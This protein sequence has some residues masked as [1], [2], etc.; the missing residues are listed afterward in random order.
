MT[1][2]KRKDGVVVI[3]PVF[4][5]MR[6]G[7]K[8]AARLWLPEQTHRN[9]RQHPCPVVLE[10]LAYRRR[11]ATSTND[12][13]NHH[14]LAKNGFVCAR[15]DFRGFGDSEGCMQD[16]MTTQEQND[17]TDTIAYLA[18]Q[19]FSNGHVGMMGYSWGG[20]NSALMAAIAPPHLGA[21]I[22][23]DYMLDRYY[24][25][26]HYR[27][28]VPL[29]GSVFWGAIMLSYSSRPPDALIH[30]HGWLP[31]WKKR[32]EKI[33]FQSPVWKH[34]PRHD[35]YWQTGSVAT[36]LADRK[37][38]QQA[39]P[40]LPI[41]GI[42]GW[43]DC[44]C[45]SPIDTVR[46]WPKAA[47]HA[48][49]GPWGHC[50]PQWGFPNPNYN[51][52][53]EAIGWFHHW[54]GDGSKKNSEKKVEKNKIES[55]PAVRA[56]IG[57]ACKPINSDNHTVAGH[58]VGLT[59]AAAKNIGQ[60]TLTFFL[61]N[62]AS[63]NNP[64]DGDSN[65]TAGASYCLQAQQPTERA[66]TIALSSPQ[67]LGG[68]V[69]EPFPMDEANYARDQQVDDDLSLCFETEPFTADVAFLGQ[70]RLQLRLASDQP[71]GNIIARLVDI[72][73]DGTAFL[74]SHGCLNLAHRHMMRHINKLTN[75]T[76]QVMPN[77]RDDHTALPKPMP[78][79]QMEPIALDLLTSGY[80]LAA[81]HRLRLS[82]STSYFPLCMP[83]AKACRLTI[84]VNESSSTLTL[85]LIGQ[86]QEITMP[87]IDMADTSK[88]SFPQHG[89]SNA[90]EERI[91]KTWQDDDGTVHR[92][93]GITYGWLRH[94][95]H[96]I[97]WQ[98]GSH[99][100]HRIHPED[101]LTAWSEVIYKSHHRLTTASTARDGTMIEPYHTASIG[102]S[103]Y[104]CD[105]DHIYIDGEL[106][107]LLN[108]Q[109]LFHKT[110]QEKIKRDFF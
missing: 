58:W 99:Q 11:D 2:T 91:N 79:N 69:G 82:L 71:H 92:V 25:D 21:A 19:D 72:H 61:T 100:H 39:R 31:L 6:D 98:E 1:I 57:R 5:T 94:P 20:N 81:G 42:G 16:E 106:T 36:V 83:P 66:A 53:H 49:I 54:L 86:V 74:I 59:A 51:F 24:D 50:Y 64:A 32:L 34:H 65:I 89:Y 103:V 109:R 76:P 110:W 29:Y 48:I 22:A 7:I 9:P 43:Q 13:S 108:G 78:L 56:F 52:H 35:H 62:N 88:V 4:I 8:L 97:E 70:P 60:K 93:K 84:A 75:A 12:E 68:A 102:R 26:I 95:D 96:P 18:A 44:Y 23:I 46:H 33:F 40:P 80:C 47:A 105:T 87:T 38:N 63:N 107:V 10:Q 45:D 77:Q 14:V 55:L 17:L 101:P 41:L 85:P 104:R 67:H 3:D 37:R 73:P 30:G 90:E 27:N 15:V 28:G